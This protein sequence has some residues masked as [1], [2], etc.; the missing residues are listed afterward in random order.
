MIAPTLQASNSSEKL[1]K[2]ENI[3][4][5]KI[6]PLHQRKLELLCLDDSEKICVTCALFGKHKGHEYR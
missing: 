4:N 5:E 6:C 3:S 2:E 1:K